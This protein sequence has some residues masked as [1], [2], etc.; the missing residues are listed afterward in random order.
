[1][2]VCAYARACKN[3]YY[4]HS[5]THNIRVYALTHTHTHTQRQ[6]THTTTMHTHATTHIRTHPIYLSRCGATTSR[7]RS[8][9][10]S[11]ARYAKHASTKKEVHKQVAKAL[12]SYLIRR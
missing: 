5:Y 1:M 3:T 8:S 4:I 9:F 11:Y 10:S 2:R 6:C 7:K 12:S